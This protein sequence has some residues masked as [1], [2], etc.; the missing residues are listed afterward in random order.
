MISTK[1]KSLIDIDKKTVGL[2]NLSSTSD[3]KSE[4][5]KAQLNQHYTIIVVVIP[6]RKIIWV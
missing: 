6:I 5:L 1:I 4:N 2:M 3:L